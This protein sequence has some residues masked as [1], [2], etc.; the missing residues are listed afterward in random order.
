MLYLHN[1]SRIWVAEKAYTDGYS[2]GSKHHHITQT[3]N[4]VISGTHLLVCQL[5]DRW[6]PCRTVQFCFNMYCKWC[7]KNFFFSNSTFFNK[8]WNYYK[9]T[10]Q[11]STEGKNK[12]SGTWWQLQ[13]L[14]EHGN[15]LPGKKPNKQIQSKTQIENNYKQKTHK[16]PNPTQFQTA[17]NIGITPARK[18]EQ[19]QK[20][21]NQEQWWWTQHGTRLM[22][23]SHKLCKATWNLWGSKPWKETG[24]KYSW[25]TN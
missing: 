2:L 13:K 14:V 17:K 5:S 10:R 19:Q 21:K 15:C 23:T 11:G 18:T 7:S 3:F 6:V 25:P 9:A 24:H 8:A 12:W 22:A 16:N 20:D 4:L 1:K